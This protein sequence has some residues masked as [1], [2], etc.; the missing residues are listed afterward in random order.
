M[1]TKFVVFVL[2]ASILTMVIYSSSIKS[3]LAY[4][5]E[6][7]GR[8]LDQYICV[9]TN[10][11]GSIAVFECVT[12]HNPSSVD[13]HAINKADVTPGLKAEIDAN[14]QELGPGNPNDSK[15]I[16]GMKSDKGVTKSPLN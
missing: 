16:G 10:D 8:E 7:F 3:V 14:V 5:Y 12:T 2:M 11:D 1:D 9:H 13:C 4:S 15:D 6:C